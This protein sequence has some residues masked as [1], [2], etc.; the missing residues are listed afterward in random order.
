M[1]ERN[2]NYALTENEHTG[3][4]SS[5]IGK[6][7]RRATF[8]DFQALKP[9]QDI[10]LDEDPI[11]LNGKVY[12]YRRCQFVS[13][14]GVKL[15]H[16]NGM[17]SYLHKVFLVEDPGALQRFLEEHPLASDVIGDSGRMATAIVDRMY[18]EGNNNPDLN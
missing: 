1:T 9:G 17:T 2:F 12:G 7:F 11:H 10:W 5:E 16:S 8:D 4:L 18:G 3:W 14:D 6:F 13:F 15:Y